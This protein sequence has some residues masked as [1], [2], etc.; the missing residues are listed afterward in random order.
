MADA[1]EMTEPLRRGHR[2]DARNAG[3]SG[4]LITV[5]EAADILGSN[6]WT[7]RR[8]LCDGTIRGVKVGQQWRVNRARL[9]RFCGLE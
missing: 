3:R 4:E 7:V 5:T 6:P 2:N 9:L 8:L 1:P